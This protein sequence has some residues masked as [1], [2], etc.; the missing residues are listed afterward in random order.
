MAAREQVG[1]VQAQL[2]ALERFEIDSLVSRAVWGE[3][4]FEEAREDLE[5]IFHIAAHLRMLPIEKLT[6]QVLNQTRA[7]LEQAKTV[8]TQIDGFSITADN[9][10]SQRTNLVQEVFQRA[11]ELTTAVSQWIPYL[12]YVRGDIQ[13]NIAGLAKSVEDAKELVDAAKVDIESRAEEMDS[14]LVAARE[15]SAA[16]GAA[17]FTKDFQGE[18][19]AT[20]DRAEKWLGATIVLT[21]VALI[22]AFVI[23][24]RPAD[25]DTT[26][27]IIAQTTPRLAILAI[28]IASAL[29]C[30]KVYKALLH[31]STLNRHRALSL[32]T[33]QAFS[34]AAS[35]DVT[36]DAVL[37]ETTRAI[38]STQSTGLI[39]PDSDG[40]G[41]TQIIDVARRITDG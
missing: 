14:I 26:P 30:G 28:V 12:A 33:F 38:F 15:A 6:T 24:V 31:L 25:G 13:A 9:A 27:I 41:S 18:S 17:V 19:D 7:S 40:A 21:V 35:D 34:K 32:Q 5:R 29:W 10:A 23:L 2:E 8:L 11:E 1:Q 4:D 37:R 39:E 22:V 16:A 36:R 3:M 20:S